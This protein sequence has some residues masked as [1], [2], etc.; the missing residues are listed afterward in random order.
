MSTRWTLRPHQVEAVDAVVRALERIPDEGSSSGVRAQVIA[1]TGAGKS[2]IAVHAARAL[3]ARR[4]LVLVPTL[5]LL[6]QTVS[7]WREAG[8]RGPMFGACSLSGEDAQ[9]LQCTT[10]EAELVGWVSGLELVTV[11]A[12]YASLGLGVLERSHRSGLGPWDLVVVDEA[13]RTSG[14]LGKAWA[15]VHDDARVPALRRLYMTATPRLWEVADREGSGAVSWLRQWMTRP[16]S[17]RWCIG[18]RCRRRLS[19]G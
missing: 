7:V 17:V 15:G 11:F 10:D 3:R 5:G 12:T 1:A 16:C 14:A 2:L 13:H 4:V 9:V 18:C 6:A 19:A 8:R